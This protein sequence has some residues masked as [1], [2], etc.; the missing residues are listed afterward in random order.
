MPMLSNLVIMAHTTCIVSVCF[1]Y[2]NLLFQPSAIRQE[3][4]AKQ[5]L[6]LVKS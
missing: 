1:M 5:P 2:A 6:G 4:I 3:V